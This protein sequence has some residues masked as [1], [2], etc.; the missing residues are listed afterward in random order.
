MTRKPGEMDRRQLLG[1]GAAIPGLAMGSCGSRE[2]RVAEAARAAPPP[3]RYRPLGRTGLQVSEIAFGAHGVDSA[4][5]MRAGLDAGIN[6]FC[7]SGSYLDGREEKA[8]GAELRALGAKRE[9]IVVLTG[10]EGSASATPRRLLDAFDASLGRLGTDR[11]DV[12]YWAQ[13]ESVPQLLA[14]GLFEAIAEAKRAGKVR[15]LGISCHGGDMAKVL[16]AAVD[17]GRFEVLFIKYDFVS[18]P[19]LDAILRR[20]AERGIGTVVFKTTAGNRQREIKD[21]EAGGLS[22]RQATI[23]WA[24]G[25]R[26]VAS[27]A[28][29][30]SSF[31][32][33][34][35][36]VG[37]VGAPLSTA[38]GEMLRRYAREMSDR[39]CRFC[40]TCRPHCPRGVAVADVMRYAMYFSHYGRE[41]EAMRLY[42]ALPEGRRAAACARCDAP[43]ERA[44]PHG[45]RVQAELVDADRRLTFEA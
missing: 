8:L 22:F 29:T 36:S 13:I 31:R 11:I 34:R 24:L 43:C 37:A 16:N 40:N 19:G 35:E 3:M 42:R 30:A 4:P 1:L 32:V 25:N 44:C 28:V 21:L 33:L 23:K 20:A 9:K 6:T 12:F 15:H 41:K 14:P 5:L 38:E 45:R 10:E 7:T 17:D 18:V 27:V 2:E 39:I 26:N